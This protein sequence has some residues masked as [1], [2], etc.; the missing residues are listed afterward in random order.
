MPL[1]PDLFKLRQRFKFFE[2]ERRNR[3]TDIAYIA[4]DVI[5]AFCGGRL[6]GYS[7]DD[8]RKTWPVDWGDQA[9]A[10][11]YPLLKALADAWVE[12]QEAPSGKSFGEV[13]GIEGGGQGKS[14]TRE[15]RKARDAQ[16]KRAREVWLEY[17][18]AAM[19]DQ[20]IPLE[21]AKELVAERFEVSF[22]AVEAAFKKQGKLIKD[23]L[24]LA[25]VLLKG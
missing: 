22:D 1:P 3:Q 21:K 6:A 10:V 12:Y 20:P 16:Y 19:I 23:E 5:T 4:L 18:H 13:L 25:G 9:V 7:D 8:L 24:I 17:L 14:R 15:R 11:P 2:A